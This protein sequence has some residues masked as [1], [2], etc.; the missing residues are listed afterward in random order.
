MLGLSSSCNS[1]QIVSI[2]LSISW[3]DRRGHLNRFLGLTSLGLQFFFVR[4]HFNHFVTYFAPW[5]LCSDSTLL[6]LGS[7]LLAT[8]FGMFSSPDERELAW[9]VNLAR[10]SFDYLICINLVINNDLPQA[11]DEPSVRCLLLLTVLTY[12]FAL[13]QSVVWSFP[14]LSLRSFVSGLV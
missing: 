14:P 6:L 11:L 9:A 8:G 7:F 13:H 2:S 4:N 3:S 5:Y 1:F 12:F 10:A